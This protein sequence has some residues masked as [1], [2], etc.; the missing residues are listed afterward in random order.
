MRAPSEPGTYVGEIDLVHEG[1]SWFSHKGSPTLRFT[2]D[3]TRNAAAREDAATALMKEYSIPE[4]PEAALP[5]GTA[6]SS[7]PP[8]TGFPMDGVPREQVMEI[9]REHGGRLVYLEEDRR[10]GPEWVSYRYFVAGR[11]S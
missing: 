4:Y 5:K 7:A 11:A 1:I 9:I 6:S 10:A 2:I 8:Q 3:V